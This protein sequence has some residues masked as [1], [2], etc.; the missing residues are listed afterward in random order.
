MSFLRPAICVLELGDG[1]Q[2]LG[3]EVTHQDLTTLSQLCS[4]VQGVL[5]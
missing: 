3:N 2:P 4:T 5:D 1:L